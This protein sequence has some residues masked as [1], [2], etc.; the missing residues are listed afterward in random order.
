M[1]EGEGV[2]IT[3]SVNE[4]NLGASRARVMVSEEGIWGIPEP[5]DFL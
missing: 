1:V 5:A 4:K 3:I 2:G